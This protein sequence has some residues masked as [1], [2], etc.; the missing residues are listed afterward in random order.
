MQKMMNLIFWVRARGIFSLVQMQTLRVLQTIYLPHPPVLSPYPSVL[1]HSKI[2]PKLSPPPYPRY[3]QH[4][5]ET[6]LEK[7]LGNSLNIHLQQQMGSF[8]ASILEAFQSLREEL[9]SKKQTEVDQTSVSASKPGTSSRTAVNLMHRIRMLVHPRNLL[10]RSRIDPKNT[11]ILAVG[12]KLN[13]G[14][15][16]INSIRNPLNLGSHL[17]NNTL[18]RVTLLGAFFPSLTPGSLCLGPQLQ[19]WVW[20]MRKAVK[21]SDLEVLPLYFHLAQ[22]SKTP[23]INLNMTLR[24]LRCFRSWATN[25]I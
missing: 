13:P 21:S 9:T 10:R 23:L 12:M 5:T 2:Q 19:S 14:L 15:P 6:N 17:L 24:L 11:V 25:I 8:Q 3:L 7:S 20:M 16:R 22:L 1:C 18:K 4:K